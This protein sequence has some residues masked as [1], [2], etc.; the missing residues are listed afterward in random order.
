MKNCLLFLALILSSGLAAQQD[1][2]LKRKYLGTYSGE[3][4]GYYLESGR[5]LM[6]V[7]AAP[8]QIE[9]GRDFV[10]FVLGN[11]RIRG[12]YKVLL[13]VKNYYVLEAYLEG[14]EIPERI[15]VFRKGKQISREG[16]YPQ[17]NALL[18][19]EG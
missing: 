8:L 15:V 1:I 19:K 9:I 10:E 17:P 2:S 18:N 6:E 5:E 11:E 16:I 13:A 7:A 14:Q 3:I 4:P 12:T